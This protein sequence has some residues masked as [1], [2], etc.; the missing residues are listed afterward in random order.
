MW[1]LFVKLISPVEW[2]LEPKPKKAI[3]LRNVDFAPAAQLPSPPSQGR[4][5]QYI[6]L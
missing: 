4:V 2:W 3:R 1:L 6:K 5:R